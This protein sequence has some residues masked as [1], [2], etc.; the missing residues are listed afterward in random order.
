[1][2]VDGRTAADAAIAILDRAD[3]EG[4]QPTVTERREVEALLKAAESTSRGAHRDVMRDLG[5]ELGPGSY[6]ASEHVYES[7]GAAFVKS[8]GYRRIRDP[9]A[10]G[11]T[12]S[13]GVVETGFLAKGTLLEGAGA[14]GTGTGG[15]LVPVPQVAAGVVDKLFQPLKIESLL[16]S[17]V[18]TTSTIRYAVEGTATNAAAG[19]AEGGT[20]P[21]STLAY[22]TTD[23]PVQK[24]AT[25][26][27]VSEE[28][29]E[30]AVAIQQFIDGRLA[31]F[32]NIE[33][34]RQL[35]R[36]AAGGSEVQGILTSRGVPVWGTASAVAGDDYAT[37]V[38]KAAN[39]MRGSAFVEPEWVV[40]HPS[41]W[42]TMRLTKDGAGGTTGAYQAGGPFSG[43]YGARMVGASNQ[44]TGAT[45]AIWGLPTYVTPVIG[46]GTALIG[47]SQGAQV[48]N[49]GGLRV[50]SSNSHGT[51]WVQNLVSLRAE[52]RLAISVYRPS[53]FVELR[54]ATA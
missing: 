11:E 35:L 39:S 41:D 27:S 43:S 51:N 40:V 47:N 50:E 25:T 30:D 37:R 23:A 38:F 15:G 42:Q 20:K 16:L 34:E 14:P 13:S 19:V 36:G 6:T 24:I 54:F 53:A 21:E 17:G 33:A 7:P 2:S 3:L 1:V 44:L 9:Q 49:R 8:D 10:R 52:R 29:L 31:L 5:R 18:A 28:L 22:S 26:T 32:V 46:A 45:D 4:R 12:W 48:W